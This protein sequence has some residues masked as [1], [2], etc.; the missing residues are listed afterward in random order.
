M[1]QSVKI[2][3]GGELLKS[4]NSSVNWDLR[5]LCEQNFEPAE[6]GSDF[7]TPA[8]CKLPAK[9]RFD[10]F[11]EMPQL[12]FQIPNG[13]AA[14]FRSITRRK[15]PGAGVV[16]VAEVMQLSTFQPCWA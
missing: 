9:S 15:S 16:S 14:I 4:L 8:V 7:P 11:L 2:S 12:S 6:A 5:A 3:R 13:A 1:C 10:G